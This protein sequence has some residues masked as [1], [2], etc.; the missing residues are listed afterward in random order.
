MAPPNQRLKPL[1]VAF[2]SHYPHL[3]MGGQRS[4]AL[5]IEHIDRRVIEPMAI[6]PG[7]GDLTDHLQALGCAVVHIP[8]HPIKPRTLGAVWTSVQR[9]RALLRERAIDIIAPDSPRDALTCGIAKLGTSTKLV[10]FVQVTGHDRLDPILERLADGIIGVCDA[11]RQRFSTTPRVGARYRTILGGADLSRFNLPR[12]R[13]A[14]RR[15]LGLPTDRAV[16]VFVGQ[17]T[18]AKG[19]LDIVEA[20]GLLPEARP[21]LVIIG[22]PHPPEIAREIEARARAAG[23]WE[24]IRMLGQREDVYRWMQ[25]ADLLVSGSHEDTE[26]MSRVLFEAMACGVVPVATDIRGNRE[27]LTPDTAVLVPE[28]SPAELGRAVMTLLG[29][30][31]RL[32]TMRSAGVRRARETFDIKQHARRVEAFCMA[33]VGRGGRGNERAER[34]GL[35]GRC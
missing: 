4:M 26:G 15:E 13:G 20:F 30:P 7:P 3:R 5:L 24:G 2:V 25:A 8:L 27:A 34:E 17:V 23:A 11:A 22:T 1:S 31:E 28:R 9:I 12:D 21:L 35:G 14:L 6:C 18:E 10:W 32:S 33:V 29:H 16:L 19:I